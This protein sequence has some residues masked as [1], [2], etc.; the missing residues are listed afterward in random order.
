LLGFFILFFVLTFLHV[1]LLSVKAWVGTKF[2]IKILRLI[3]LGKSAKS[4][5]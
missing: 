5:G 2:D 3:V 4:V 1:F